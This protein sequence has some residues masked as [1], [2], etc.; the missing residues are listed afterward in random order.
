MPTLRAA[1]C[2]AVDRAWSLAV[3]RGSL[4]AR[5]DGP[6]AP[7]IEVERP[8][9]PE[10]GDFATNLAMQLARPYRRAPLA[11]ADVAGD[12]LREL[13]APG[14]PGRGPDRRGRGGDAG[15]RQPAPRRRGPRGRRRVRSS[16]TRRP[17][18]A[19]RS[20][21]P[22]RRQRGVRVGQ[23]DRAAPRRQRARRLRRRPALPGP[24][25]GRP[26]RHARVLLQRFGRPDP[27]PR[28]VRRGAPA[29]RARPGG[30]LQG[31]LR[32]RPGAAICP[33]RSGPAATLRRGRHGRDRRA[34][35]RPAAS[36]R[37]SR[38]ASTALG[39]HFDV[40]TSE[41][42]APRRG[43]GRPG[44]RAA[45]RAA[46]TSTSR[47]GAVWFRSTAFGD[48]KDRVIYPL[49]R[50]ADVLRRRHRL[51]HREVQPRLRPPHLHLGRRPP[52][53]GRAG[54]ERRRG[55]GLRRAT[56]SR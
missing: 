38:R 31:R 20:R 7:R 50:R 16:P 17:G 40:W 23:P 51:R 26:A 45:P 30:R 48:D 9:D 36:A 12:A 6:D 55:D 19:S 29:R 14:R 24:R 33:T 3:E 13:S 32:P 34:T 21:R 56:R 41:A 18:G 42:P 46:A 43:L 27:Q 47:T 22:A 11:I 5:P 52:R 44:G 28:R 15:V 35:G 1:V 4:P 25:G 49:E 8:A 37:G 2:D 54:P 53:D 10:H 39:V